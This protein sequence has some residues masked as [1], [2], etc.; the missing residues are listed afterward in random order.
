MSRSGTSG[1]GKSPA[2]SKIL[3][4][5]IHG[6]LKLLQFALEIHVFQL[7]TIHMGFE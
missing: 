1:A 6:K 4:H 2:S 5:S 3:S 7:M